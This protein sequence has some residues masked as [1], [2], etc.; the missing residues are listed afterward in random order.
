M[1]FFGFLTLGTLIGWLSHTFSGE[2]GIKLLPSVIIGALGA[3]IGGSLVIWFDLLGSGYYATITAT[4]I[5]FTI[6]AF[7]KKKPIFVE[8]KK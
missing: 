7:R 8:P 1:E 4:G 6:N 5:L 3:L 2:H